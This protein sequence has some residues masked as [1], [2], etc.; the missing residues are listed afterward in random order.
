MKIISKKNVLMVLIALVVVLV[1][2]SWN[3]RANKT[4]SFLSIPIDCMP[5]SIEIDENNEVVREQAEG[6]EASKVYRT[7]RQMFGTRCV[8]W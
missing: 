2:F 1:L 7:W 5:R 3:W 8:T 4:S 6:F